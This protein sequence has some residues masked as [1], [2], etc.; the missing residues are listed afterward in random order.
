M[1]DLLGIDNLLAELIL[2]IGLAMLLGNAA[3]YVKARRGEKPTE[4]EGA[5]FRPARAGFFI[6]T[7]L[8]MTTWALASI[9]TN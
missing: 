6:V 8:V 4:V 2:G 1:R 7:G 3:A 5:S 9:L